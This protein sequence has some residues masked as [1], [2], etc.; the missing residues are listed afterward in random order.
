MVVIVVDVVVVVVIVVIVIVVVV[1]VVFI[2]LSFLA[3]L[4]HPT[5]FFLL[6]LLKYFR[7]LLLPCKTT[8]QFV[9]DGSQAKRVRV[10]LY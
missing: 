9:V 7:P 2:A 8:F 10:F 1:V 3:S 5:A 4:F 6:P